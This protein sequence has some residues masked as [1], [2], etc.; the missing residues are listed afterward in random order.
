M[1]AVVPPRNGVSALCRDGDQLLG[2]GRVAE[3]TIRYTSAFKTHASS[4]VAHMRTLEKPGLAA[5]VSTLE[6]WLDGRGDPPPDGSGSPAGKGLAAVFLSTLSPNNLSATIFKMES[7]LQSGGHGCDEI[8]ARCT[9]LLA[10]RRSPRPEGGARALLGLTRA[11][12]SLRSDPQDARWLR[13]YLQAH[14]ENPS[15]AVALVRRRQAHHLPRIVEAFGGVLSRRYASSVGPDG[16]GSTPGAGEDHHGDLD[17]ADL[18]KFLHFLLAVTPGDRAVLEQQA[19]HLLFT[20]LYA[21]SAEAYS[22]LLDGVPAEPKDAGSTPEG[23]EAGP[24]AE[25]QARLFTGRAAARFSA[26]GRAAEACGDLGAAFE[27]HPASA[28]RHFRKSFAGGGGGAGLAARQHLRQQADRGLLAYR[29]RVLLRADLRSDEGADL[30]DP[31]VT[32]L[33]TLCRLEPGGG[34]REL[35]VRLAECLL[36]RG[37]HREALSICSQL[38]AP[39]PPGGAPHSYHNTVRVL[40]GYARVLA[41]DH[42][43]ATEDFQAVIEHGAPHPCSCVRAL[44]GR[45]LLRMAG[46]RRYLAALDYVTASRL[47]PQEAGLTLRCLVPWNSRGLLLAL[48]L[49]QGR[50]MLEGRG[51]GSGPRGESLQ[52]GKLLKEGEPPPLIRAPTKRDEH[53]E[54]TPGGVHC[55]A[56]LLMELQPGADGPQILAADALYQ[57]GRAEEA[58][59][60]LLLALGTAAAPRGPVLARLALLQLNRGFMYDANQLLKKL[61]QCGDT[62]CLRPLLALARPKDKELLQAHC[63]TASQRVLGVLR[64]AV[65]YLSIAIMASGG[66]AADSLLERARCYALLGQRK[67]AIYD[68]SAILKERPDHVHALCGRGFTYLTLDQRKECTEDILSALRLNVDTVTKDILSLKD[69]ARTLVCDWLEQYCRTNQLQ[70][71]VAKAVPCQEDQLREAFL[72]SGAL[73]RVDCRNP[74]WHLLYVDALLAKGKWSSRPPCEVKAAGAH[75]SQVFGQEP[76]EAVAQARQ[77]V[78]EAWQQDYQG[79]AQRLSTLAE[80]DPSILGFL[81]SLL[82]LSHRRR[83]TQAAA[84][85]AGRLSSA[86]SWSSTLP[87]LTVAVQAAAAAGPRRLQYLRQRA[88]CLARLGLHERAVADLD[89][90]IRSHADGSGAPKAAAAT[91]EGEGEEERGA[92]AED[93]CRRGHSLLLSRREGPALDDFSRALALHRARAVRCAEAGVGRGPLGECFLRGALRRYGEQRLGEAWR[94]VEDGLVLDGENAGLRRLRARVKR[95]AGSPCNVS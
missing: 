81:L 77:G 91:E 23:S 45:G 48:L 46:G 47:Q 15:E 61:I 25:T 8:Y 20:G 74:R 92:R 4:T 68:F 66:A 21:E 40:R 58:H 27:L 42:Q 10:G 5:V 55:L 54:G 78:V 79:A 53:R 34:E 11:L 2:S 64:E 43:G 86:G 38:A 32:H 17:A 90:V 29:E 63:H 30:L 88:A 56:V 70:S 13:L 89:G 3:A 9:A 87:L 60:L 16:D 50:V 73:L 35:R 57:L 80:K 72:I 33:R 6:G 59:R 7:L 95:E 65:A 93:L 69:K 39:A 76:R 26:G 14:G 84:Q 41:D 1:A 94:L 31:A 67:T 52:P 37:E 22:A 62:S 28:R 44:C 49:E 82:P 18:S 19:S 12:A 71:L 85:E 36:L 83:V 24:D 75:L 51:G